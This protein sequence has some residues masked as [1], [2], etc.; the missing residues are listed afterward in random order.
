MSDLT[1]AEQRARLV[2]NELRRQGVADA[3]VL[4]AMRRVPREEFIAPELREFAYRNVALPIELSQT[5][6]QPLIVAM[7]SQALKL[8]PTDRVLEV[9]TGSGYAAAVLAELAREVFTMERHES[10]AR[11]AGERLTHLGYANVHVVCGDG[12]LGWPEHA[13]YDAI[14]VAAGGPDVPQPLLTQLR[15]G[16]R[17]VIPVGTVQHEQ[18]LLRMT[19]LNETEFKKEDLGGVRFVPLIGAEGWGPGDVA[20][21]RPIKSSHHSITGIPALIREECEPLDRIE[22]ADFGPLL[23]RIG[24]ARLVLIGEATHG[25]SEFYRIRA[26]ITK[27]L[28]QQRG[29]NFVAVEADWPDAARINAFVQRRDSRSSR[30]WE[31]FSRFPTWMWRNQEVL[32]FINWLREFNLQRRTADQRVGFYGLDLYNLFGSIRAVLDYL[33]RVDPHTARVARERYGCLTPWE[34][35]PQTYGRAALTGRYRI[36]EKEAVQILKDLLKKQAEYT[37]FDGEHFMDAALNAKLVAD[38]ERY[39]RVMYYGSVESWNLRDRHM[40]ETL[41]SL[42]KHHGPSSKAVIWE[43]NSHL[44]DAM[45]T[46]MGARQEIN[47]GYLCHQRFGDSAY[48]IG[49][50][51]DHGT[52][53]AAD[54]W[55]GPMEVMDVV[56][57]RDGSYE[58]LCHD[59]RREAFLLHLRNPRREDVRV[60]LERPLLERAIGVIYRP[61]TELQSH[62]FRASLPHQFD[63]LIWFDRSQAVQPVGRTEAEA[64]ASQH[65]FSALS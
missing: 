18:H 50:L 52:V 25:T 65:P 10:L 13:P 4:D 8:R 61:K 30:Q 28:I 19:R 39:Y 34:G 55:D 15:I 27:A 37:E 45:A 2:N 36:C 44:G 24:N 40:F 32:D 20:A 16:G 59:S 46:D 29:F 6:S 49:Q 57:S 56:P 41:E 62:Y 58:R 17:L 7:M 23:D 12:T 21:A 63:E 38:A 1:P 43:H 9:G 64:F 42:L 26:E 60:E 14:V 48:L 31:A 5:I 33:D 11:T 53:A 3:R 47:V 35:D 51:T 22:G 54:V